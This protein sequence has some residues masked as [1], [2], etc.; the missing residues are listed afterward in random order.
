[1]LKAKIDISKCTGCGDCASAC[2][3]QCIKIDGEKAVVDISSC[4]GCTIC[5]KVCPEGAISM[6]DESELQNSS[7][8]TSANAIPISRENAKIPQ[9]SEYSGFSQS[10]GYRGRGMGMGRGPGR[11]GG[12]G[13][14]GGRGLGPSGYC[15]CPKCGTKIAHQRG[16]PCYQTKCPNCGTPMARE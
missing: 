11:G 10:A 3:V 15:V 14:G 8:Q 5:A 12:R 1:M 4:V 16:V 9:E 13:M 7:Q 2:P 6:V